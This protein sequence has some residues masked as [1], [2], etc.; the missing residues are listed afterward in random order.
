MSVSNDDMY[1]SSSRYLHKMYR[2]HFSADKPPLEVTKADYL[3]SSSILEEACKTSSS[4]FGEVTSNVLELS[5]FS[6]DG[7]FNPKNASSPYHG[8][9]KRGV[10]IEAFIRPDEV[11]EWDPMG[12]FYVTDWTTASNGISAE[13]IA[14]DKLYNI[15][16]SPVPSFNIVRDISFVD[17]IERYFM[18]FGAE[19]SVDS[20]IQLVLPYGFTSGYTDNRRL[21]TDLMTAAIADCFCAHD[22]SI[23]VKSK[24]ASRALRATLT[25]NDQLIS[26]TIKQSLST[27]YDSASITCNAPQEL[28]E[29]NVLSIESVPVLPGVTNVEKT[30][31]S[32]PSVISVQSIK[33]EGNISAK[34][35]SFVATPDD[36]TC[37]LHS[38]AEGT[39][40]LD[41]IGVA[42]GTVTS[43][44]ATQG[45]SAAEINSMFVQTVKN[46]TELCE[47][48]DAYVKD[49]LSTID[50]VV[51]GNP[52]I[53]IGDK[54]LVQSDKYQ[55]EYTGI[56]TKSKY[57]YAGSL[58]CEM[59]LAANTTREV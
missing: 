15:L 51:R 44:V 1:N 45:S 7:M 39:V 47:F 29:Q 54:V 31:F 20:S 40:K 59:T 37:S 48:V 9:I 38:T 46:A 32:T 3:L 33:T 53:Q 43:V 16:N 24:T 10:K 56:V 8:L 12:V 58:S 57:Q 11:D 21:L 52:L 28:K 17:F 25:D 49:E 27:D 14:N 13:V 23:V 26:A 2:I 22:G 19:V 30:K 50:I 35:V 41:V 5:L 55:L 6:Q 4:P 34:P 36:I 42:L 18:M